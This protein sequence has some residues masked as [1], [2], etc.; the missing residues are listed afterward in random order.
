MIDEICLNEALLGGAKE[1][2][3]TMIFVNL[4]ESSESEEIIEGD[5]LLGSITFKGGIEGCLAICCNMSCAKTIAL[6]MLAMDPSDELSEAEISDAIGEVTNMVMGGV[7]SRILGAV[8]NLEVSIPMVT[9]GQGLQN[10]LGE[11]AI[12][13]LVKVKFEN[14]Y[15][16]EMSILYRESSE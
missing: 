5:S 16:A 4:E 9:S 13:A 3:E 15:I 2:F 7:K 10:S 8:G 14:E 1:I 11:G 6:N 12:K